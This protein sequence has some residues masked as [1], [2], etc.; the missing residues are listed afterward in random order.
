MD[1]E[2]IEPIFISYDFFNVHKNYDKIYLFEKVYNQL[3][4]LS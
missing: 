3:Y 4:L 2:P 1:Y